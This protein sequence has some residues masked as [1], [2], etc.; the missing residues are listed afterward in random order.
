MLYAGA[1]S[2]VFMIGTPLQEMLGEERVP[3]FVVYYT[4][5]LCA[6]AY[7]PVAMLRAFRLARLFAFHELKQRCGYGASPVSE[8]DM[9]R[10]QSYKRWHNNRYLAGIYVAQLLGYFA[11]FFAIQQTDS[12]NRYGM[13]PSNMCPLAAPPWISNAAGAHRLD[14]IDLCWL[15]IIVTIF[16]V[17]NYLFWRIVKL[18]MEGNTESLGIFRDL[19]LNNVLTGVLYLGYVV[20]ISTLHSSSLVFAPLTFHPLRL[21]VSLSCS[22]HSVLFYRWIDYCKCRF[23]SWLATTH[24]DRCI[25]PSLLSPLLCGLPYRW[26]ERVVWWCGETAA[27][28]VRVT[29]RVCDGAM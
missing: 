14:S 23:K 17:W 11:T 1:L 15:I 2:A 22:L 8:E 24:A 4:Y 3:C 21:P 5:V 12:E 27:V 9:Q 28:Y 10:L 13:Q 20:R 19:V 25:Q 29:A 16:P 18:R 7:V 6:P 26:S